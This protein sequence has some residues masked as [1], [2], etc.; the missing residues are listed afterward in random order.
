[1]DSKEANKCFYAEKRKAAMQF[2]RRDTQSQISAHRREVM[3]LTRRMRRQ[4][5]TEHNLIHSSIFA[6]PQQSTSSW[7]KAEFLKQ[8]GLTIREPPSLPEKGYV[9][10][11][12]THHILL[13]NGAYVFFLKT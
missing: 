6:V 13:S 1:M 11:I 8:T 2:K 12:F 9:V 3:L 4:D 10:L 5:S 7:D